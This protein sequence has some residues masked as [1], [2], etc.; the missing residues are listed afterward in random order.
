MIDNCSSCRIVS[1]LSHCGQVSSIETL[2]SAKECQTVFRPVDAKHLAVGVDGLDRD[3]K[4]PAHAVP[5]AGREGVEAVVKLATELVKLGAV[6]QRFRGDPE[7]LFEPFEVL[8][9]V[10]PHHLP[11]EALDQFP[12]TSSSTN[13]L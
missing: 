2:H 7:L 10:P 6:Q 8:D 3:R 9:L 5:T 13:F 1:T 11:L 12:V 4:W